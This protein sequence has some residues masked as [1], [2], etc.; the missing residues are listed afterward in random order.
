MNILSGISNGGY[1]SRIIGTG[2][3][4]CDDNVAI[5]VLF[6]DFPV[7]IGD[8][9]Y[10]NGLPYNCSLPASSRMIEFLVP[11]RTGY[12]N[13]TV[14]V[15][16]TTSKHSLDVKPTSNPFV[17]IYDN[18]IIGQV[19][20]E[21]GGEFGTISVTL[22]GSNFCASESCCKTYFNGSPLDSVY[23]HSH[24]R[25]K[26]F[27]DRP[28]F[29]Q[30]KC[31]DGYE[32]DIKNFEASSP[33]IAGTIPQLE[34]AEFSTIGGENVEVWGT[35]FGSVIPNIT[36]GK[37]Q[38]QILTHELVSCDDSNRP[39]T[40]KLITFD[41][42]TPC[43][44]TAI[45]VPEGAGKKLP[46]VVSV[47]AGS[48][49]SLAD[50]PRFEFLSYY[51]PSI[52]SVAG[53]GLSQKVDTAGSSNII[54]I[55]GSN[56]YTSGTISIGNP[57]SG[58]S[59]IPITWSHT[60]ITCNI[61]EGEG[62]ALQWSVV[63]EG[64][65]SSFFGDS[66]SSVYYKPP[67]A[68]SFSSPADGWD[69]QGNEII[70]ITG[71]NLGRNL[72]Q[73]VT[74]NGLSCSVVSSSHTFI[75]C[76]SPIGEGANF[77]LIVNVAGQ[78]V[79][80]ASLF[81]YGLPKVTSI[82][83]SSSPT[84]GV[85]PNTGDKLVLTINGKNFGFDVVSVYLQ[86]LSTP[87]GERNSQK[88]S[89][90][91]LNP[92]ISASHTQLKVYIPPFY[93]KNIP[94]I[95]TVKG[96]TISTSTSATTLTYIEPSVTNVGLETSS[97]T[98]TEFETGIFTPPPP[99]AGFGSKSGRILDTPAYG[100]WVSEDFSACVGDH[101]IPGI[102]WREL[103]AIQSTG[104]YTKT[105]MHY[106][107]S[108]CKAESQLFLGTVTGSLFDLGIN[109]TL[110]CG[111]SFEDVVT[112]VIITPTQLGIDF[113]KLRCVCP[114]STAS[115]T[116]A[117]TGVNIISCLTELDQ[118]S[119]KQ[120]CLDLSLVYHSGS[121]FGMYVIV[122]DKELFLSKLFKTLDNLRDTNA[123]GISDTP[124]A[125]AT[126]Y[127]LVQGPIFPTDGCYRWEDNNEYNNRRRIAFSQLGTS[128]IPRSCLDKA[129]LTLTGSNFGFNVLN[130][131]GVLRVIFVNPITN[132]EF[133]AS[134]P[135]SQ[136]NHYQ[137]CTTAMGCKHNHESIKVWVPYG[138]G[139]GLRVKVQV[140][141]QEAMTNV[142]VNYAPPEVSAMFPGTIFRKAAFQNAD[143]E[144]V[145]MEGKNFGWTGSRA[146]VLI[147][148]RRCSN[149]TWVSGSDGE[150]YV[151][152]IAPR[153]TVGP[154]SVFACV[155]NQIYISKIFKT[156]AAVL[157]AGEAAGAWADGVDVVQAET[158]GFGSRVFSWTV[159]R[160]PKDKYGRLYE[161]CSD[162]P[163]GAECGIGS[164]SPPQSQS[165][166]FGTV[167][168]IKEN[169]ERASVRCGSGA[170]GNSSELSDYPD[171]I[172]RDTCV[173]FVKCEPAESCVGNNQCGEEYQY[174][175]NKCNAAR[176]LVAN[177]T[178]YVSPL[179]VVVNSNN[180]GVIKNPYTG[181]YEGVHSDCRG[182]LAIG[183][184][185]DWQRPWECSMCELIY[186][187]TDGLNA[188]KSEIPV[189]Q[190]TCVNPTRC[191][192]CT[193]N[194]HYRFNN[195]CKKCP[196]NVE[197]LI[198]LFILAAISACVAAYYLS[199][200]KVNLAFVAIA[201]DYFQV[202]AVFAST[203]VPW[204]DAILRLFELLS[205][206]N[207]NI[208]IAAPECILP[209]F[210]YEIKFYATEFLPVAALALLGAVHFS[211]T[212][213]KI[214]RDGRKV[215][216]SSHLSKL[217]SV[218]LIIMYFL[219]LTVT[220]RALDIFNCN[221]TT[222]SDGYLYTEFTSMKCDGGGLCRC[223]EPGG[224]QQSLVPAAYIFIIFYSFGFP[225]F[226]FFI[227]YMNKTR[228][229]E[230]QYLR[231]YGIGDTHETNPDAY[232]LRKRYH[233]LYMYY[234]PRTPYWLL[235]ILF[236][237]FM[238]VMSSLMFRGNPTFQMSV[239][240]LVLFWAFVMQARF[241][242]FLSTG[243]RGIVIK[244]LELR[245]AQAIND[246]THFQADYEM[247]K[248]IT[249]AVR[250]G[251]EFERRAKE[252][253]YQRKNENFWQKDIT[254]ISRKNRTTGKIAQE[255]FFD[256][257]TV[258]LI[259]LGCSIFICLCGIMFQSN[260]F[261]GR[262][263]TKGERDALAYILILVVVLSFIYL[264][265]IVVGET[266]PWITHRIARIFL[267]HND[268]MIEKQL[269]E[270]VVTNEN[271]L[272]NAKVIGA[273]NAEDLTRAIE[274]NINALQKTKEQ[275]KQLEADLRKLKMQ[276]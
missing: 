43:F 111:Q 184:A 176:S 33:F 98:T 34:S 88:D 141:N 190:C 135:S 46:L 53:S 142:T 205:L 35:Y 164:F 224:V 208:D 117:G 186:P 31:I 4:I 120:T 211:Y 143:G 134:T 109:P 5:Q 172:V 153:D 151:E 222:P 170:S 154:K 30:I 108:N 194:T 276:A 118:P 42:G 235:A 92:F 60:T 15:K 182:N 101:R 209:S 174:A 63:V 146:D 244:E 263:D 104:T 158:Q 131:L 9:F 89:D 8:K 112:S 77:L 129:F 160:C 100:S 256:F 171:A 107:D 210:E 66:L 220:K 95:I 214:F 10:S 241:R 216:L 14:S 169:P 137:L 115:F 199:K 102:F 252:N 12:P 52:S 177:G 74:I 44:K 187:Q 64:S 125:V 140:G 204:P 65:R 38:V 61:G 271:P 96:Q 136:G 78:S 62:F 229:M 231:A 73:T 6:G 97:G 99:N 251:A 55:T 232:D 161:L 145:I 234:K 168:N 68:I 80:A 264:F 226:V 19:V 16:M 127:P 50:D 228:V 83:P 162:C 262:T 239:M 57:S 155:A 207:I 126:S 185:C 212:A 238:I 188:T 36:I 254:N 197:V 27:S 147:N 156:D 202:L 163:V 122:N 265:L 49:R 47:S 139:R 206:F 124:S 192:L 167:I 189:G 84:R 24:E 166:F 267:K 93:G 90:L 86:G 13:V 128:D 72:K 248:K 37:Y 274:S 87:L 116:T 275:N 75:N 179:G 91:I 191:A 2:L 253:K 213:Y 85:D 183:A 21:P 196:Q 269:D 240:L 270:G 173:D 268:A 82:S 178:Q 41:V 18:P 250:V 79:S 119:A 255:Y 273:H 25:I 105:V 138:S 258:E 144:R 20:A 219:Y 245:A 114:G 247:L 103:W 260:R 149:A 71:L 22:V 200:R 217:I 218:F 148:G 26:F 261:E 69:T 121:N 28:G 56:F 249:T 81:S 51:S 113:L 133:E 3:A 1:K 230:D 157:A 237:K 233:L 242:P 106:S 203:R 195:A 130:N 221:P 32:T 272:L 257:N 23:S 67:S 246:P 152:C 94:L 11:P 243:E 215:K 198:T 165:G 132:E 59:C 48:Q 225:L 45:R 201:V 259:L 29:V 39:A 180:C 7:N 193:I 236:R 110:S 227:I 223:D 40:M 17:F 76:L 175:L 58:I 150:P 181:E 266:A 123:F 70:L 54:T 159:T